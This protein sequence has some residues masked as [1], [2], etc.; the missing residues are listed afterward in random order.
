MHAHPHVKEDKLCLGNFTVT[1]V[2]TSLPTT[3]IL[4][5]TKA[6]CIVCAPNNSKG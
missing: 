3:K 6:N 4:Q 1:Q 5:R 2:R